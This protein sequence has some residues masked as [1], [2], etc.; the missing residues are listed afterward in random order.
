MC[1]Y[2]TRKISPSEHFIHLESG[3]VQVA[4]ITSH[5]DEEWMQQ[6][7]RSAT[8]DGWGHL[9]SCRYVLHDRDTKRRARLGGLLRCYARAA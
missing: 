2:V 5:P 7:A 6:M 1:Y 3:R 9:A 4:G 8:Q